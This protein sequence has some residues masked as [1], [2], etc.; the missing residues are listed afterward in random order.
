MVMNIKQVNCP[1]HTCT[2][3][4]FGWHQSNINYLPCT[5]QPWILL[6]IGLVLQSLTHIVK[7][8]E[9][10]MCGKIA[11]VHIGKHWPELSYYC[12]ALFRHLRVDGRQMAICVCVVSDG[13]ACNDTMVIWSC[14]SQLSFMRLVSIVRLLLFKG[15]INRTCV[16][17]PVKP[18]YEEFC[19]FEE[20]LISI[21]INDCCW[22]WNIDNW[23]TISYYRQNN[24][25]YMNV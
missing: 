23:K 11:K 19:V 2:V 8:Q 5:F 7:E 4:K 6:H 13:A 16:I 18:V 1:L 22:G 15:Y 25:C 10:E 24:Q 17:P 12:I 20:S 14:N 3:W 9:L 21:V